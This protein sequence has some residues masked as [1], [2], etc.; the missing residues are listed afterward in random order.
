MTSMPRSPWNALRP[1]ITLAFLVL[2]VACGQT[3]VEPLAVDT[4]APDF[5]LPD[6]N[7]NSATTGKSVSPRMQLG[8]V[9]AWYFGHAT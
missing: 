9:S 8:S 7:P 6:V 3:P 1:V 5:S 4:K 2:L